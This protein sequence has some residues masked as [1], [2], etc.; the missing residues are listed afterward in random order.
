MLRDAH[1][2]LFASLVVGLRFPVVPAW[3]MAAIAS[4]LFLP[5]TGSGEPLA[6]GGPFP[7]R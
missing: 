7:Y 6:L 2:R 4:A 1:V 5:G 3:I